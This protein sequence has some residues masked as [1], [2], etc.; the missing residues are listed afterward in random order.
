M[1]RKARDVAKSSAAGEYA[2]AQCLVA[3]IGY[4]PIKPTQLPQDIAIVLWLPEAAVKA[5][6]LSSRVGPLLPAVQRVM[7]ATEASVTPPGAVFIVDCT[8]LIPEGSSAKQVIDKEATAG[9]LGKQLGKPVG[10][11]LEKLLVGRRDGS[12][13]LVGVECG[14]SLALGLL[15]APPSEHGIKEGVVHRVMLLKPTL[16]AAVVNAR[17]TTKVGRAPPVVDVFYESAG[18]LERRDAAV[19]H[20]Y[21]QGTSRALD[22]LR[23]ARPSRPR[24]QPSAAHSTRRS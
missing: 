4:S 5:S 20:A 7:M 19:R 10:R 6:T 13:S 9:Q 24:R 23:R 1:S 21:A 22:P 18:A 2:T 17:L 15:Q 12:V 11:L 14:A 3:N 8:P 16:S